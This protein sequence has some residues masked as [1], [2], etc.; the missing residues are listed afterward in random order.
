MSNSLGLTLIEILA[1]LVILGII[2][3]SFFT[4]FSQ[5]IFLSKK[6]EDNLTAI[7]VGEKILYEMK[8]TYTPTDSAETC[9]GTNPITLP[10]LSADNVGQYY[11]I[12]NKN[13]YPNITVCQTSEEEVLELYQIH[14]EI[15]DEDSKL[16]SEIFDYM[17]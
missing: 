13:Y 10:S 1:S 7:N 9:P 4:F 2:L 5:T 3:I 16:L 15:F 17:E 11:S 12:N 6:V 8:D 14:V